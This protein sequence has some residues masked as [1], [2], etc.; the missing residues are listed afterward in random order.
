MRI[1]ILALVLTLARCSFAEDWMPAQIEFKDGSKT[2]GVVLDEPGKPLKMK[3]ANITMEIDRST[4]ASV[5]VN[6]AAVATPDNPFAALAVENPKLAAD[7]EFR[8][9]VDATMKKYPGI[10]ADAAW[11]LNEEIITLHRRIAPMETT[12]RSLDASKADALKAAA[13]AQKHEGIAKTQ[14][15]TATEE[16]ERA[17]LAALEAANKPKAATTDVWVVTKTERKNIDPYAG[18]FLRPNAPPPKGFISVL[19]LINKGTQREVTIIPR[20]YIEFKGLAEGTELTGDINNMDTKLKE[21]NGQTVE[22]FNVTNFK[23]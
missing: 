17:R 19:T 15:K 9:L 4:V 1:L 6:K 11:H 13:D 22:F 5:T 8:D 14:A 10:P 2:Q 12:I 18:L 7:H 23:K 3:R 16:A 21:P 20:L